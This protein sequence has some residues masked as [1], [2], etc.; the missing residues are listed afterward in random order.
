MP[1]IVIAVI[2]C[3]A[4]IR[5]I[6]AARLPLTED[7][8]Y[9]WQWSRH[10]AFGYTDHPPAVAWLIAV[11]AP[12]DSPAFVRLGFVICGVVAAL[13]L[14]DTARILARRIRVDPSRAAFATACAFSLAP[15][16]WFMFATAMPDPPYLA[17]WCVA[18]WAAARVNE[19]A[20]RRDMMILGV[21]LGTALLSRAFGFA[22]VG[23]ILGW[24]LLPSQRRLWKSGLGLSFAVTAVLY[25]PF[26]IWNATHE[27]ANVT[28]SI[29]Q[30]N[31]LTGLHVAHLWPLVYG[32]MLMYSPGLWLAAL[33][34]FVVAVRAKEPLIIWTAVPLAVLLTVLASFE[35]VEQYWYLGPYASLSVA[36]GLGYARLRS[37]LRIV[38]AQL[39]IVPALALLMIGVIAFIAPERTYATVQGITHEIDRNDAP[40]E[41][42]VY[43]ALARD[44]ESLATRAGAGVMTTSYSLA[45]ELDY[46]RRLAPVVI[47]DDYRGRESRRWPLPP[48]DD[49]MIIVERAAER[50][51]RSADHLLAGSCKRLEP[52]PVLRYRFA[53]APARSFVTTYCIGIESRRIAALRAVAPSR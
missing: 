22:L 18:L 14:A 50:E 11:F 3:C 4:I 27:W 8:A 43:G 36:M 23:G 53:S 1:A 52:G 35:V 34:A 30:R 33:C 42:I 12:P 32:A 19:F 28:F 37:S 41:F 39:S 49:T 44:V 25:A 10:L 15:V 7:E 40:F 2:G 51:R 38:W 45:A 29:Q 26:V 48:P 24:S 21:A 5:L 6:L 16:N 31:E 13:A 47:G 20:R 46:H 9:Y 17:S